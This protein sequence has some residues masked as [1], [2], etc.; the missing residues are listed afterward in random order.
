MKQ[1]IDHTFN[2]LKGHLHSN[3]H[4]HTSADAKKQ[5]SPREHVSSLG[6]YTLCPTTSFSKSDITDELLLRPSLPHIYDGVPTPP[7]FNSGRP[8]LTGPNANART[9]P[10]AQRSSQTRG[11][12]FLSELVRKSF[13]D[14]Y[15]RARYARFSL[16]HFIIWFYALCITFSRSSYNLSADTT[17][18]LSLLLPSSPPESLPLANRPRMAGDMNLGSRASHD[19]WSEW[20]T[21]PRLI[22]LKA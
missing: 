22:W 7:T 16:S 20:R 8:R 14:L 11:Q 9:D 13:R 3:S 21:V 5:S 12:I 17:S 18:N 1:S 6:E 10:H 2:S 15:H 19:L 4:A